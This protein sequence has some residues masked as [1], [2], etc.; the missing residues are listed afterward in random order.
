MMWRFC[1]LGDMIKIQIRLALVAGCMLLLSSA[2]LAAKNFKTLYSF[3]GQDD[4]GNPSGPLFVDDTGTLYG[5]AFTSANGFGSGTIFKLTAKR[6]FSLLYSFPGQGGHGADGAGPLGF[7]RDASGNIYDVT[8]FGGVQNEYGVVFKLSATG[9]ER[10]LHTFTGPPND[11]AEP[12]SPL[13]ATAS[14][15]FYG[16][17]GFG[18][19]GEC[20]DGLPLC[21]VL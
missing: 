9:R 18:G 5:A 11:G 19:S 21:G 3:S 16:T 20:R 14:G 2:F 4:G 10:V 12:L 17:T 6:K 1:G 13:L 8:E 15:T 7:T